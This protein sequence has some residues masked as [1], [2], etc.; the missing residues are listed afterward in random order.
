MVHLDGQ[1]CPYHKIFKSKE[2][3][4]AEVGRRLELAWGFIPQPNSSTL[5]CRGIKPIFRG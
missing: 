1:G 5:G 2:E 4:R 3:G